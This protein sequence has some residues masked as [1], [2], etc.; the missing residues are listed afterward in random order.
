MLSDVHPPKLTP[1][2]FAEE[3]VGYFQ[4]AAHRRAIPLPSDVKPPLDDVAVLHDVFLAFDAQLALLAAF[5]V[6]A[7]L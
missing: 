3:T 7:E 4:G 2:R 6:G 5:G 1:M